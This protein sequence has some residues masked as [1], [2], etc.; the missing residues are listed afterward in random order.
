MLQS[1]SHCTFYA[2]F[3][4]SIPKGSDS[5]SKQKHMKNIS[6]YMHSLAWIARVLC[7]TRHL[8]T[9]SSEHELY[10]IAFLNASFPLFPNQPL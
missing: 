5:D 1:F 3:V 2:K 8:T 4:I 6:R 7:R 10:A 9:E